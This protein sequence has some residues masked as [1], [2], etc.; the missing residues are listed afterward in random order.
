MKHAFWSSVYALPE[1]RGPTT[2]GCERSLA[3]RKSD[4]VFAKGRLADMAQA[5]QFNFQEA[6]L[7]RSRCAS[8]K[9]NLLDLCHVC[10]PSLGKHCVALPKGGA[11]F[12][13]LA[14][15]HCGP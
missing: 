5:V 11:V 12:A 13:G 8:W 3:F 1:A 15:D 9:L 6:D 14:R 10:Q 7:D 2:R 4:A